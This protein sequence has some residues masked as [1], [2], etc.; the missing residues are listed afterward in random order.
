MTDETQIYGTSEGRLT[1][2]EVTAAN[3]TWRVSE[4]FREMDGACYRSAMFSACI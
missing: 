2:Q 3:A 4:F 1:E